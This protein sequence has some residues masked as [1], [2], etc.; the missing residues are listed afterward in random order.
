MSVIRLQLVYLLALICGGVL[1]TTVHAT[2]QVSRDGEAAADQPT[3]SAAED[4][5][6]MNEG[7]VNTSKANIICINI[8]YNRLRCCSD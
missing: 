3:S 6:P 1:Y 4:S 7:D 8:T 2:E 5:P